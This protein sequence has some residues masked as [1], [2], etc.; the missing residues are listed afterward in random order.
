MKSITLEY[1]RNKVLFL[2]FIVPILICSVGYSQ[3]PEFL[4]SDSLL[5][6]DLQRKGVASGRL[7][8]FEEALN[9]FGQL[10]KLR[11]KMF[12]EDSHRLAPP[13]INM[14]IQYKNIGNLDKAVETY[15]KAE[16]LYIGKFGNDFSELGIVYTNLG[17]IYQLTGDYNKALEYQQYARLIL[18]RDSIKFLN[19]FQQVKFNI[20]ETQ[21]KLGNNKEAIRFAE[22]NLKT[23]LPTLKPLLYDLIALAYRNEGQFDLSEKYYLLAIKSWIDLYGESNVELIDEYLAY[24]ALLLSKKDFEK[25][26]TYSSTAQTIVLNFFG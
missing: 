4:V 1:F 12:G 17:N 26:Y 13:L 20:A 19:T 10:Y 21:F 25:A 16:S 6:V 22:I 9:Y 24:S 15:K 3:K 18:K 7:G 11:Q 5:S 23:I 14:G 8:D 2:V